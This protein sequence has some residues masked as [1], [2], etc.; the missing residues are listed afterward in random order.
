[1]S[2]PLPGF[3]DC[4]FRRRVASGSESS[5]SARGNRRHRWTRN[6]C[7]HPAG[8]SQRALC[9]EIRHSNFFP[10]HSS[11]ISVDRDEVV[12]TARNKAEHA[13]AAIPY[14]PFERGGRVRLLKLAWRIFEFQLP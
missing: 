8:T 14:Q 13:K 4:A 2:S 7:C 11:E 3:T 6:R 12:I 9:V 5:A 1:M 10:F